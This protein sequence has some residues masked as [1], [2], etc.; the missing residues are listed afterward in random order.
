MRVATAVMRPKSKDIPPELEV[1]VVVDVVV[2]VVETGR[3]AE[4]TVWVTELTLV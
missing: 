1:D 4:V 3:A 2:M